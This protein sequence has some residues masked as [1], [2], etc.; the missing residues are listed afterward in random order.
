MNNNREEFNSRL[1]M[2]M[3][4]VGSA[5]GLGNIWRFPFLVG[6]F[7][8]AA[9]IFVYVI[10]VFVLSIP[11]ML[12]EMTI[13][14]SSGSNAFGAYKV[15]APGTKW[16]LVGALTIVIPMIIIS[17][18]NVIGGWSIDYLIKACSLNFT[19]SSVDLSAMFGK[20]ISSVWPPIFALLACFLVTIFIVLGGV[21]KGIE[22][23]GK[24][25]MPILFLVM[26][27]IALWVAF[28]PGASEGLLYLFKPD[29][30]KIT[31]DVCVAA[32]GQA[33]FSLSLG[34]G[35]MVTYSSY[36]KKEENLM[37]SS[38]R[39]ALLDLAFAILASAAIM[40]AAFAYGIDPGQGPSLIFETLPFIFSQMPFG[41]AVAIL[42]FLAVVVAA[43]TS[44]VSL[45]EVGIAY[46]TEEKGISRKRASFR[47]FF[48]IFSVG[49][50]CSLSFGPLSG[51]KIFGY[52]I[53]D[54]LDGLVANIFMPV[55]GFLSCVF[56]GW[57]MK[58][59]DVKAELTNEGK[60]KSNIRIYPLVYFLIRYVA[61]A[62]ILIISLV[63]KLL[64]S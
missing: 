37:L 14:R 8:G 11:I 3:A 6:A 12:S 19:D 13:G 41:A 49:V 21:K 39:I 59:P 55:T 4:I 32:M 18:Y 50:L 44:T 47:L 28:L 25:M 63:D 5:V 35:T 31:P 51:F 43:L 45:F 38:V 29:F 27:V 36:I 54:S 42:F 16:H 61:P 17:Y 33:F 10:C 2:L 24:I 64:L 56:V 22:K 15:L 7:G 26:L 52:T 46:L 62:G 9:F 20:F 60:L 58:K 34:A 57:V 53:F 40:P 23:F 48:I 1:G 30:S